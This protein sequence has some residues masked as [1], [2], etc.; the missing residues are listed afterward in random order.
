M[1]RAD[2]QIQPDDPLLI[3]IAK[4]ACALDA[5]PMNHHPGCW[6]IQ[7]DERWWLAVN[8]HKEPHRHSKSM[9]E[10]VLAPF[11]FYVEYNGWPAGIFSAAGGEFV[12]GDAAN[13][14]TF[15]EALKA[16]MSC[17]TDAQRRK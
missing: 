1:T 2:D 5:A 7:I 15:I 10:E 11:H 14:Q 4:F 12:A 9:G 13:E 16:R 17:E 3:A 8:G 6:E